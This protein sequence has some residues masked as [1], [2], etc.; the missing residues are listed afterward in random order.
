MSSARSKDRSPIS[1]MLWGDGETSLG[2]VIIGVGSL[3]DA[4]RRSTAAVQGKK[5]QPRISFASA[6]RLFSVLTPKRW[7]IVGAMTGAGAVSIREVARRVRRDVKAV[8]ADVQVLLRSGVIKKTEA[9]KIIFPFDA[10]H[11]DFR[12]EAAA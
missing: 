5:Q 7:E 3:E 2:T 11:V 8:H 4:I 10:V 12:I 9:G 6:Q 1:G